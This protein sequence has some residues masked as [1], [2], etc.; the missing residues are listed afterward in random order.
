MPR[1]RI[2]AT[3]RRDTTIGVRVR[4]AELEQLRA[5]ADRRGEHLVEFIRSAA[6]E[7][8]G[9][10]PRAGLQDRRDR[11]AVRLEL[12]AVGVNL[13]QVTRRLHVLGTATDDQAAA[14]LG[15]LEALIGPMRTAVTKALAP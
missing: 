10:R 15:A 1:P 14:T 4:A 11:Q 9:Q 13:N 7:A 2:S 12:H 6:L 8:A 3:L 5:A